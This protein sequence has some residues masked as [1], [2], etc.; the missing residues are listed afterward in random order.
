MRLQNS[1]TLN[2]SGAPD[3]FLYKWSLAS[4]LR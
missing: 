3:H 2:N 1:Q 4:T